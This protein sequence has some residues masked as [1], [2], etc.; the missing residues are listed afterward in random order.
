VPASAQAWFDGATE[1]PGS[2]WTTWTDW[3]KPL[4]GKLVNAPKAPGSAKYKAIEPAP[5]RYVK[6]K[7]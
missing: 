4:G 6:A 1:H 2:W 5:G 7:A 3:L